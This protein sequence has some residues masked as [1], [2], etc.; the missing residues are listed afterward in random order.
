MA[1]RTITAMFDS[2]AEAE[3]AVQALVSEV[4][5]NRS[6][7]RMD[8]EAGAAGGTATTGTASEDKGFFE[9]LKDLFLPD[10]DRYEEGSKIPAGAKTMNISGTQVRE[11]YLAK[12]KLL[13]AWFTRPET[14]EM[15]A[16]TMGG[17]RVASWEDFQTGLRHAGGVAEPILDRPDR[18]SAALPIPRSNVLKFR[19]ESGAFAAFRPSGTEPKL[20]VYLQSRGEASLLDRLEEQAGDELRRDARRDDDRRHLIACSLIGQSGGAEEGGGKQQ[21]ASH[22]CVSFRDD[23][24]RCDGQ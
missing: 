10:E 20:K 23:S 2:R 7:V 17:E 16:S 14:A 12:G 18:P 1:T 4:G 24:G 22:G 9:S 5:L 11:E 8:P 15:M 6:T 3:Q 13:P 21:K 19:F